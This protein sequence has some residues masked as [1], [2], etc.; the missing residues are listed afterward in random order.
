MKLFELT[1][2]LLSG[3]SCEERD[4]PIVKKHDRTHGN[5]TAWHQCAC[6]SAASAH[7]S[8][9]TAIRNLS[10]HIYMASPLLKMYQYQL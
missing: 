8:E 6:G 9:R 1:W 5:G 4:D 10:I 3:A 7:P 2:T